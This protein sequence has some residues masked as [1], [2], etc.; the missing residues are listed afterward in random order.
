MKLC[1]Y[2]KQNILFNDTKYLTITKSESKYY[3]IWCVVDMI[4]IVENRNR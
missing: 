3:H 2:C 4:E 1:N